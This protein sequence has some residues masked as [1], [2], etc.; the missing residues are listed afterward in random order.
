MCTCKRKS[1]KNLKKR[2]P[3]KKRA[4]FKIWWEMDR[5]TNGNFKFPTA[6]FIVEVQSFELIDPT[7]DLYSQPPELSQRV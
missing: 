3:G 2:N 4:A 6:K 5:C 1:F 7:F